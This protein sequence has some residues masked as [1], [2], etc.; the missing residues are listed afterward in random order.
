MNLEY[1]PFNYIEA[2]ND[3]QDFIIRVWVMRFTVTDLDTYFS[4]PYFLLSNL[5]RTSFSKLKWS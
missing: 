4:K 3:I 2:I 1:Y 5:L